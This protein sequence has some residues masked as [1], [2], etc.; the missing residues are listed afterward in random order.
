MHDA[1]ERS[2]LSPRGPEIPLRV[3]GMG[4]LWGHTHEA[5]LLSYLKDGVS[6]FKSR[7]E[8][9]R[10]TALESYWCD[11]FPRAPFPNRIPKDHAEFVRSEVAAL[12]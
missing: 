11:A 5:Q 12:L 6:A 10:G 1:G 3:L 2:G 9:F 7:T 8:E 4:M